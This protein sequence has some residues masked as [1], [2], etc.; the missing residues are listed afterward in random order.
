MCCTC[1][2]ELSRVECRVDQLTLF[3]QTP[4][5]TA[6]SHIRFWFPLLVPVSYSYYF[7]SLLLNLFFSKFKSRPAA[8]LQTIELVLFGGKR[9]EERREKRNN[10]AL[11]LPVVRLTISSR[12][13]IKVLKVCC[14]QQF[15]PQGRNIYGVRC[16]ECC[17]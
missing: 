13:G 7:T 17:R 8:M 15:H 1:E 14:H 6:E 9:E 10:V 3:D 11:I 16:Q 12:P 4:P 5:T 2:V